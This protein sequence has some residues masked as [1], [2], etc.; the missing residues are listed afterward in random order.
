MEGNRRKGKDGKGKKRIG[1]NT[2]KLKIVI[3][4]K[5]SQFTNITNKR[6]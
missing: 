4:W 5:K 2:L 1:G 3:H 6:Q